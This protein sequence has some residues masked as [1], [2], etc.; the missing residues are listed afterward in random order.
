MAPAADVPTEPEVAPLRTRSDDGASAVEYALLI[1]GI[2]G[3]IAG[4]VFLFGPHVRDDL[5]GNTCNSISNQTGDAA[6]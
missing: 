5:F 4:I 2:A 6:C 1:A 3:L